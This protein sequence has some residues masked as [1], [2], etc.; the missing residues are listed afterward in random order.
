MYYMF[1]SGVYHDQS[2]DTDG[3]AILPSTIW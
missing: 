1:L 2:Y 3:E